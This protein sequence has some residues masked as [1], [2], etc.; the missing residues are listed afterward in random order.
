MTRLDAPTAPVTLDRQTDCP[1]VAGWRAGSTILEISGNLQSAGSRN[2]IERDP[3]VTLVV[4][5]KG[6]MQTPCFFAS[7]SP[8]TLVT[9]NMVKRP[10]EKRERGERGEGYRG[11]RLPGRNIGKTGS[12]RV[13]GS[14]PLGV[15][16]RDPLIR[17]ALQSLK[18]LETPE[19]GG[20]MGG[21]FPELARRG[22]RGAP[23]FRALQKFWN[24]E[25]NSGVVDS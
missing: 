22:G 25:S 5:L 19:A 23:A 4:T 16:Q 2:P 1:R 14:R 6:H 3:C 8:V 11:D 24:R 17:G 20:G 21:S 18:T 7:F 15:G 12:H 9:L 10:I 13:T